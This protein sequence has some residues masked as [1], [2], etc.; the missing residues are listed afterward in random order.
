MVNRSYQS[1]KCTLQF[2]KKAIDR[3]ARS[4]RHGCKG[5][6]RDDAIAVIQNFREVHLY[7]LML[8][9]NH[10]VRASN[11]VSKNIIVARRLKRLLTIVNKLERPTLD[12]QA[13]NA[14]KLTRMQDIGGCRAI[15]KNLKEL[16][17]LRRQLERSKSVHQIVRVDDYLIPKGSGYG[18][19]HLI[20]SCY[21]NQKIDHDYKGTKIEFQL[22]TELQHAWATS[23]EII[24]TLEGFELKTSVEGN[25]DWREFFSYAGQL[26]AHEEGAIVLSKFDFKSTQ[27]NMLSLAMKLDV[28]KKLTDYTIALNVTDT[29]KLRG[30][31]PS[32]Q[33]MFLIT[34]D[35]NGRVDKDDRTDFSL[36]VVF[37]G[38]TAIERAFVDLKDA[39]FDEDI[40]IAVLVSA[41]DV[42][43]LKK[44]YPN[45][46]G[47]TNKFRKFLNRNFEEVIEDIKTI[48]L[49]KKAT[50]K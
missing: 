23:L 32:N 3:A 5:A 38:E 9:K 21:S 7:P 48:E 40:L 13:Q 35:K 4:I 22:R 27:V 50:L 18:G 42:K 33:G 49:E 14:I 8:M 10:L 19:L 37:Y 45:Y 46:F 20:Y 39:E 25:Q 34:M 47:S 11:K 2:S 41:S 16:K 43:S 36:N 29:D 31:K 44:A 30:F 12:G 17:S 1:Q 24:D 15:V 28:V 26:V 6:E